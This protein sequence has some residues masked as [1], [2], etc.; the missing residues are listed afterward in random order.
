MK[1]RADTT[2]WYSP[3]VMWLA[4]ALPLISLIGGLLMVALTVAEPDTEVHG[5]RLTGKEPVQGP[6]G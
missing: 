4:V 3:P 1:D 2:R 6:T 5:E